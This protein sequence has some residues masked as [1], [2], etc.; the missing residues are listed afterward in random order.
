MWHSGGVHFVSHWIGMDIHDCNDIGHKTKFKAGM[1]IAVEPGIYL[2]DHAHI[3]AEYREIGVRIED[4][5]LITADEPEVLTK[6]CPKDPQLILQLMRDNKHDEHVWKDAK[7]G[8]WSPSR[9]KKRR[10]R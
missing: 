2:P 8:L 5:V 6:D 10:T 3:K 1:C 9:S 4:T 7:K